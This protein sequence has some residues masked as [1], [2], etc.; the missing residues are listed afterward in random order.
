[1]TRI[2]SINNKYPLLSC[3]YA[4]G[5]ILN[6]F[7]LETVKLFIK[8]ADLD[9][10]MKMFDNAMDKSNDSTVDPFTKVSNVGLLLICNNTR[11][12]SFSSMSMLKKNTMASFLSCI[13]CFSPK[14]LFSFLFFLFFYFY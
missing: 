13:S 8:I 3:T 10:L 14:T 4:L 12:F 1:M 6:Y 5:L 7:N 11:I 9:L 2:Y